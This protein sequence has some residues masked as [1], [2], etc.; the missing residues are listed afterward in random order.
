MSFFNI[1]TKQAHIHTQVIRINLALVFCFFI[2][3]NECTFLLMLFNHIILVCLKCKL[4]ARTYSIRYRHRGRRHQIGYSWIFISKYAINRQFRWNFLIVQTTLFVCIKTTNI[5]LKRI[6]T[7]G[8]DKPFVLFVPIIVFF[9]D[10]DT[11]IRWC[12]LE[13]NMHFINFKRNI[14]N[15]TIQTRRNSKCGNDAT[16][17]FFSRKNLIQMLQ[18]L[19][20]L[21]NLECIFG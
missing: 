15:F 3:F 1:H 9:F 19:G 6:S 4:I 16:N 10:L 8:L 5:L 20:Y 14:I 21:N 12:F 7:K 2:M 13:K 18:F 11:M 17:L